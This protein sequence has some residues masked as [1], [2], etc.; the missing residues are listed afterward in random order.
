M[1][2]Y[3]LGTKEATQDGN[4]SVIPQA[5]TSSKTSSVPSSG[6]HNPILCPLPTLLRMWL[7]KL[8]P[9]F[10]QPRWLKQ[11]TTTTQKWSYSLTVTL[12]S[13]TAR[14][15]THLSIAANR[16]KQMRHR[17]QLLKLLHPQLSLCF[18][19]LTLESIHPPPGHA[20]ILKLNRAD[21]EDGAAK[22]GLNRFTT[23]LWN[24]V[25]PSRV[26]SWLFC[27]HQAQSNAHLLL[28]TLLDYKVN[29]RGLRF[30]CNILWLT[31]CRCV[32]QQ[33]CWVA[34]T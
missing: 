23:C 15:P 32:Q 27:M 14:S 11:P 10:S 8:Q 5:I 21:C 16:R 18:L 24:P 12:A 33:K 3:S 7:G 25:Q 19:Q 28:C 22:L 31:P 29:N 1:V 17:L 2:F 20:Q 30:H 34:G 9:D 4:K 6:L 13:W 26:G